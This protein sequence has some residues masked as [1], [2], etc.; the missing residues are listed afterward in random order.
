[1][2]YLVP[3]TVV[4]I[5]QAL[6]LPVASQ[7]YTQADINFFTQVANQSFQAGP[8]IEKYNYLVSAAQKRDIAQ[9]TCSIY[10]AGSQVRRD[11]VVASILPKVFPGLAANE[12]KETAQFT[13]IVAIAGVKTY[14]PW[15]QP[16]LDLN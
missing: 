14:C 15:H 16:K 1:M 12:L 5:T 3:L 2:R 7:Q 4:A 10:N 11:R 8:P 13:K 9:R 6:V